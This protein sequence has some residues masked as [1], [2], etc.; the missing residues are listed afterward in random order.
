M[1]DFN[2]Y[3]RF[4]QRELI[5]RDI[6][7]ADRTI[8]ANER[9]FLAYIR[10]ALTFFVAGV[11]FVKFFGYIMVEIVGWIFIPLGIFIFVV[12]LIRYLKMYRVISQIHQAKE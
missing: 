3:S 1:A 11:T 12:G 8:L 7:A 2:P 6:L 10:T 4:T 9:T 5:L